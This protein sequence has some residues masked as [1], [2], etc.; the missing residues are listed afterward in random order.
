MR[1]FLMG[2]I[3]GVLVI[4]FDRYGP[5]EIVGAIQN[6]ETLLE[7][8]GLALVVITLVFSSYHLYTKKIAEEVAIKNAEENKSRLLSLSWGEVK[9]NEKVT[10]VG[11]KLLKSKYFGQVIAFMFILVFLFSAV[12]KAKRGY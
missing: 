2:L 5:D 6:N 10:W 1:I 4:D 12:G 3:V 8:T 11:F 7:M 9:V